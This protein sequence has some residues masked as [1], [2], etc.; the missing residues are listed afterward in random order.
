MNKILKFNNFLVGL[1]ASLI[2]TAISFLLS[3]TFL[4]TLGFM[5]TT[6]GQT[7]SLI[8]SGL[9]VILILFINGFAIKWIVKKFGDF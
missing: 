7:I 4:P 1:I 3:L 2:G 9:M 8:I 6:F 5:I